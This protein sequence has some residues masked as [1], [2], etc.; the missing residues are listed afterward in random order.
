MD[1]TQILIYHVCL[2]MT[3]VRIRIP[4]AVKRGRV[5]L[6][7]TEVEVDD[8]QGVGMP[9][10]VPSDEPEE[11]LPSDPAMDEAEPNS[12]KE[13]AVAAAAAVPGPDFDGAFS[14]KTNPGTTVVA[15]PAGP[16]SADEPK[17]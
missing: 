7:S 16:T 14:P 12:P 17:V 10:T 8:M 2:G 4:A 15:L 11:I 1:V 9:K 13:E 3:C 5:S 6:C